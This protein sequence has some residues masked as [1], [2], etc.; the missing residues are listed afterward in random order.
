[1]NPYFYLRLWAALAVLGL[2]GCAT[3][4]DTFVD[5]DKQ[6]DFSKYETFSWISEHPMATAPR[7]AQAVNPLM[8]GRIQD[9]IS[10]ELRTRGY[11][12]EP[13]G[14][15]VDF[16]VSFS[17]SARKEMSVESY[18]TAYRGRWRWGGAYIGDSVSVRSTMEGMLSI[19]IFDGNTK[20][21]AWHGRATKDLT[22]ADQTLRSSIISDAVKGILVD[23]P[24]TAY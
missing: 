4:I 3:T 19:D 18:P 1:M 16:V 8:E 22:P 12:F 13:V 9:A 6:V 2:A 15:D 24:P 11:R 5:Y 7:M 10:R 21:P 20:S 14:S 23:F 17:V